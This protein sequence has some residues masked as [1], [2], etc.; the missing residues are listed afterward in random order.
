MYSL[1]YCG[2][3]QTQTQHKHTTATTTSRKKQKQHNATPHTTTQDTTRKDT[4]QYKTHKHT[5]RHT[6]HITTIPEV[7]WVNILYIYIYCIL[8]CAGN[9]HHSS[10]PAAIIPLADDPCLW[11]VF[12][13]N[14]LEVAESKLNNYCTDLR[15][16]EKKLRIQG[17]SKHWQGLSLHPAVKTM[18]SDS[19][20]FLDFPLESS[21]GKRWKSFTLERNL[22]TV[23]SWSDGRGRS[24]KIHHLGIHK[25]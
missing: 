5:Q 3:T 13:W 15:N 17:P 2:Q 10:K 19:S 7:W 8:S 4:T 25:T 21:F 6:L 20:G 11:F 12:H 22:I 1:A 23:S 16:Y 24:K 14:T 9:I 18:T